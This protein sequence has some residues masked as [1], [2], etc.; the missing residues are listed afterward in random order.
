M[1]YRPTIVW[2]DHSGRSVADK[3]RE[4]EVKVELLN[5]DEVRKSLSPDLGFSK[6]DRE[7][8]AQ[9]TAYLY[10]LLSR[11][12]IASIVSSLISP[13]RAS[14]QQAREQVVRRMRCKNIALS[15]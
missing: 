6:K 1:V 12:G 7:A 13:Y 8:H 10:K 11:N 5:G 3:L 2:Q 4:L 14:R 9:R 15:G